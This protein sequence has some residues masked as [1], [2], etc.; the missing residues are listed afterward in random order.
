MAFSPEFT[1]WIAFQIFDNIVDFI[2]IIDM[3]LMFMTSY[4]NK[5]GIEVFNSHSIAN[6]YIM[7]LRFVADALAILGTGLITAFVPQF[8]LFGF[9][10]MF[11]IMRLGT[12]ITKMNVPEHVKALMNLTKLCFYLCLGV[13]VIGCGWFFVCSINK[14]ITNPKTG[15]SM[16]WYPPTYWLDYKES[17]LFNNDSIGS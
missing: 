12:L 15:K 2:F 16:Q 1:T 13:H 7:S 9:F 8:K 11:R 4:L 17:K 5:R 3:M 14:D 10:K 6:K